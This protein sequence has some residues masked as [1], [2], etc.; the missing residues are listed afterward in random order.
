MQPQPSFLPF[1][2]K[3]LSL[4]IPNHH[5]HLLLSNPK[6]LLCPV[7]VCFGDVSKWRSRFCLFSF[8][9]SFCSLSDPLSHFP[10]LD[11]AY[12]YIYPHP[13]HSHSAFHLHQCN[14]LQ[15][16]MGETCCQPHALLLWLGGAVCPA[17]GV[18]VAGC[19]EACRLPLVWSKP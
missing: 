15:L 9:H 4:D 11:I 3:P 19:W 14:A 6:S 13:F 10:S 17:P 18:A 16:G 5:H 2:L 1:L 8:S 7:A 12:V